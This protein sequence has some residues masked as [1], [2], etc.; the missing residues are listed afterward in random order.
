MSSAAI[1][2][3]CQPTPNV[4]LLKS[5]IIGNGGFETG[6]FSGWSIVGGGN[7]SVQSGLGHSG[8]YCAEGAY[9]TTAQSSLSQTLTIP[10]GGNLSFWYRVL[11]GDTGGT[12]IVAQWN[13]ANILTI[14]TPSPTGWTQAT[15]DMSAYAG[16]NHIFT[17]VL[18]DLL[19]TGNLSILIDDI[20][21]Q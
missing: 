15:L 4:A 17:I 16:Q 13:G 5:N 21:I 18:S 19:G 1:N 6:D 9:L 3:N 2:V 20:S 12:N 7:L 11:T 10:P 8:N 14:N